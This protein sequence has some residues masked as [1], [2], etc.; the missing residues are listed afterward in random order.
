MEISSVV[1][2]KLYFY[3]YD[4][5]DFFRVFDDNSILLGTEYSEDSKQFKYY[6]YNRDIS[7]LY[8]EKAGEYREGDLDYLNKLLEKK[9][10]LTLDDINTELTYDNIDTALGE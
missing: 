2:G 6:K 5:G 7:R 9:T 4:S 8:M 3:A 1:N 10:K